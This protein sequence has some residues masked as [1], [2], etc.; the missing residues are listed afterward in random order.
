MVCVQ[1]ANHHGQQD[2]LKGVINTKNNDI[3]YN[4]N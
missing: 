1:Y 3:N 4:V 2:S